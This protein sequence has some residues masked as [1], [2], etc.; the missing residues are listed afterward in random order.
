MKWKEFLKPS[1]KKIIAFI[2]LYLLIPCPMI[3]PAGHWVFYPLSGPFSLFWLIWALVSSGLPE[4]YF[5]N[6]YDFLGFFIGYLLPLFFP[7]LVYLLS[8]W[9]VS[10]W[11]KRQPKKQ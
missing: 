1:K 2:I 11:G 10:L 4:I 5:I 3:W 7:F 9:I 6:F 8:C